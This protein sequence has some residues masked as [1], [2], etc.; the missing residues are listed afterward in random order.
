[1]TSFGTSAKCFFSD[2]SFWSRPWKFWPAKISCYNICTQ[3]FKWLLLMNWG[4]L[5]FIVTC[6]NFIRLVSYRKKNQHMYKW[7]HQPFNL[8][9]STVG[10]QLSVTVHHI[11]THTS[12]TIQS[13]IKYPHSQEHDM[14]GL[15]HKDD[16][17]CSATSDDPS[18]PNHQKIVGSN[19]KSANTREPDVGR[20]HLLSTYKFMNGIP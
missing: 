7:S 17:N 18:H 2:I 10:L 19:C 16:L 5:V 6:Y 20:T 1:M 11:Q 4:L 15:I 8:S 13:N 14:H 9:P 12:S 3:Y